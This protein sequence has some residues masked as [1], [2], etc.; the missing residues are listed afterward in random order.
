MSKTSPSNA[1]MPKTERKGRLRYLWVA[2][3]IILLDQLTKLWAIYHLTYAAPK[4]VFPG[5]NLTLLYNYGAAFSFLDNS[6]KTWQVFFLSAIAIIV[7]IALLIWMVRIP[8]TQHMLPLGLC[9]IVG[10]AIGN[11]YDRIAYGYVIDFLD[12][13]IK[14]YHWPAFN[15]ADSAICVGAFLVIISS[16][17]KY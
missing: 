16:F 5:F 14:N 10:G 12:F 6:S 8:R 11:L 2:A 3:T 1:E 7:I 9:L 4:A 17:R 13:Y 15:I